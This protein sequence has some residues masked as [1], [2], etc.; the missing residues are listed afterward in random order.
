MLQ[1]QV[2]S[3]GASIYIYTVYTMSYSTTLVPALPQSFV[4]LEDRFYIV[5]LY[6][7]TLHCLL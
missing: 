4:G 7:Q 6:T 3:G 2:V 5:F 1:V